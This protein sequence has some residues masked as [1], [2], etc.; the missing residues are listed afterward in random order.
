M[1]SDYSNEDSELVEKIITGS[2]YFPP[3]NLT[4]NRTGDN[5]ELSWHD[6][7]TN[8]D[9]FIVYRS[10]NGGAFSPIAYVTNNSYIDV[11]P[12]N[13][14]YQYKISAYITTLL[15][16]YGQNYTGETWI[17]DYSNTI[18]IE[19]T[20]EEEN[21]N[22]YFIL[23]PQQQNQPW[24]IEYGFILSCNIGTL[25]TGGAAG[26]LFNA[27]SMPPYGGGDN[28]LIS[29][30]AI[31]SSFVY[32]RTGDEGYDIPQPIRITAS[33]NYNGNNYYNIYSD[34]TII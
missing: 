25:I 15:E 30:F 10:I 1:Y 28:S 19:V 18:T 22:I 31:P 4:G 7:S 8:E 33:V 24:G 20:E 29:H 6:N 17:S 11:I 3:S 2:P 21:P 13:G 32:V 26:S 12:Y 5:N 23:T 16:D 34:Y 14:T 27:Y 9:G